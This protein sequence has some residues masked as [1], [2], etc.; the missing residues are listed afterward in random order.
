MRYT[1]EMT[2]RD[3]T[4]ALLLAVAGIAWAWFGRVP[5]ALAPF[6]AAV[7]AAG[8]WSLVCFL[9]AIGETIKQPFCPYPATISRWFPGLDRLR[10]RLSPSEWAVL[11]VVGFVLAALCL[12]AIQ[13]NCVGRRR[14][15]SA[16]PAPPIAEPSAQPAR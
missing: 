15:A 5:L 6:A 11:A 13:T 16:A 2:W 12:P 4:A 1:A 14:A 7:A 8:G 10:R 9:W 3:T